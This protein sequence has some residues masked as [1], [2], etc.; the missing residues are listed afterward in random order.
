M[1]TSKSSFLENI[2][3]SLCIEESTMRRSQKCNGEAAKYIVQDTILQCIGRGE[4]EFPPEF[5]QDQ[6]PPQFLP[7]SRWCLGVSQNQQRPVHFSDQS[8]WIKQRLWRMDSVLSYLVEIPPFQK[9]SL[10]QAPH[11]NF[12]KFCSPEMTSLSPHVG[13]PMAAASSQLGKPRAFPLPS[14]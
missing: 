7:T 5:V 4:E 12:Q 9:P 10:S 14:F 8:A 2:D 11:Q 6:T 1:S 3:V 13:I